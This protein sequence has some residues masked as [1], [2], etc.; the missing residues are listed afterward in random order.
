[1]EKLKLS[2]KMKKILLLFLIVLGATKTVN[3][4]YKFGDYYEKDGLKGI[5]V[6]VDDSGIH[7]LIMSLEKCAKNG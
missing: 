6:R 3:A 7:G 4:Q 1:M 5:V 2:H